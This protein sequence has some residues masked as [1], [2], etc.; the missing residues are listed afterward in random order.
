MHKL[1]TLVI[2]A[3][4]FIQTTTYPSQ[5]F[6]DIDRPLFAD[7]NYHGSCDPEIVWIE[8][9]KEWW[10]FYTARRAQRENASYVGTPIGVVTSKDL[11][12]WQFRGY[13]SFDGI[14]G[15]PDMDVTLW[16]PGVIRNGDNYHMFVTYKDN[17]TPPWGGDGV[18]RHYIAPAD[19][20]L[21]GWTLA[22]I[23]NFQQP[24][25]IDATIIRHKKQFR[26]Y[27]RVGKNG[28]QHSTSPDLKK[29]TNHGKCDGAVNAPPDERGFGY[30]EAP[31]VFHWKDKY[32]MITD[33][34]KGLA[35]F[36][37]PDGLTWTQQDSIM[38]APGSA[39]SDATRA[40][41][42]SVAIV[43][44]RAFIFYHTEPNRPYPSPKA[45][46]RTPHQ[47]ISYLQMAELTIKDGQL[48]C[49]R[50]ASVS[51]P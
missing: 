11:K 10:I 19:N 50:D 12:T 17:A 32:W 18:I 9:T 22:G 23:P 13:C 28:I 8:Q 49:D 2:L 36:H 25:P 5:T 35:V 14:P 42:P 15:A 48:T 21:S 26:A 47:K 43:N 7:P 46:D 30:Q 3:L 24:D 39:P 44:D 45:E 1:L 4:I 29:W 40:R 16:A 6:G 51:L 27:Y 31:Y 38:K 41:H 33:P 37:S 20:L 34:H